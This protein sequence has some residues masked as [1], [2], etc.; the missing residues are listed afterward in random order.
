MVPTTQ[1]ERQCNRCGSGRTRII[2]QS[3]SPPGAFVRCSDC[4]HSTLV[5]AVAA[6][7][8]GAQTAPTQFSP[9]QSDVDNRRVAHLVTT[10]IEARMLPHHVLGVDKVSNGWRVT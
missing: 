10:V 2:A 3:I 4:G 1:D 8:K 7:S 5:P 6:P 9:S